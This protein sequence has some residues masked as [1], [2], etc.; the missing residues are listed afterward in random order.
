MN[1]LLVTTCLEV[2]GAE[3]VVCNL[4]DSLDKRGYR[5]K[6]VY[7]KGQVRL[8]PQSSKVGIECLDFENIFAGV[9]AI[10]RLK[11]IIKEFK[12]DVVHSHLFH[13]NLLC[14]LSRILT[15]IPK[16]ITTAHN[17]NEEG[18]YRMLLYR[19][20][21]HLTDMTTNVSQE[22]VDVF[23]SEKA[24]RKNRIVCIHNGIDTN[25]FSYQS[26]SRRVIFD[27]LGIAE[28]TKLLVA[29][30][31]L[32]PAKDYPNLIK[33]L[34]LLKTGNVHLVIVGSGPLK[35]SL[36]KLTLNLNLEK[37]I[38]FFGLRY[39]I[40]EIMS[41][42][43]LFILS[44]AWEGFGLVVAEAMACER[45]VIATDC[46]GVKEVVGECGV[47]I[48]SKNSSMLASAIDS[49]LFVESLRLEE[50]GKL[51]RDR[52]ISLYSL[53]STTEKYMSLYKA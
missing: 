32:D 52:I 25:K 2:G 37:K 28:T 7:L 39:D 38:T 10:F 41:A 19:L 34:S 12:P 14:R 29:V 43:D 8:K 20:T 26:Q 22:A 35:E 47:V 33:A 42:A 36:R 49:G 45:N 21:D 6:V 23:I 11:K 40:P 44:S 3:K 1:V 53:E 31:R 18:D 4:A 24:V 50:N 48:P 27:E 5:V 46:G 51:A 16:L 17:S 30:G 9:S 15:K 13:A